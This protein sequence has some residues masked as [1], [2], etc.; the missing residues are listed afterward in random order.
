MKTLES[1]RLATATGLRFGPDDRV[2]PVRHQEGFTMV[3]IALCLAVVGFA[4]VAIIGVLPIGMRVQADN[5]EDTFVNADGIFLLESIRSGSRGLDY[6]TNHFDSITV[7]NSTGASTVYTFSPT[8]SLDKFSNGSQI[9]GLLS[10]PHY[11]QVANRRITN[12]VSAIVRS[13]NGSA[14]TQSRDGRDFAFTYRLIAEMT[15][16]NVFPPALTNFSSLGLDQQDVVGRSNN[17][18]LASNLGPN[19]HELRLSIQWPVYQQGNRMQIGSNRKTLRT[20]VNG[21]L[22]IDASEGLVHV[23]PSQ[24]QRVPLL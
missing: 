2:L 20:L 4:L 16:L 22:T 21:R 13:I 15:P 1:T 24:Y 12:T 8:R 3:E 6:L 10:T 9:L 7:S 18:R 14:L 11:F 23:Q 19:F 5:R 17:W